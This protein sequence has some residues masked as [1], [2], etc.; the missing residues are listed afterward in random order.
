MLKNLQT[1]YLGAGDCPESMRIVLW[2]IFST[3]QMICAS[4]SV[5]HKD[6]KNAFSACQ[7]QSGRR[8][9]HL[10]H[11]VSQM[12]PSEF[13]NLLQYQKVKFEIFD[14][15]PVHF[16]KLPQTTMLVVFCVMTQIF[17]TGMHMIRYCTAPSSQQGHLL[18]LD[19][20]IKCLL[21]QQLLKFIHTTWLCCEYFLSSCLFE[22]NE[23]VC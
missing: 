7:L 9:K 3:S 21:V 20:A 4:E 17:A 23:Q 18:A 10:N 22:T 16:T 12:S 13:C 11:I 2:P 14:P 8:L 15:V 6:C 5:C 1:K 19:V